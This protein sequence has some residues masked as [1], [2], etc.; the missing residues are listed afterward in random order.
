MAMDE[1]QVA[2]V[3]LEKVRKKIPVLFD[4]EDTFFSQIEKGEVEVISNRDM[5]IPL[6]IRPGGRFGHFDPAGGDLGRGEGPGYEKAIINTVHLRH[7]IEWHKKTEWATDDARKAVVQTVKKLLASGMTEFRRAVDALAVSSDGT[8]TLGVV[9]GYS[10]A[11]GKDTLTCASD[12]YGVR[13]MR[14]GQMLSLYDST[15]AVRKPFVGAATINGE[16]PI[17]IHDLQNKLVRMNGAATTPVVGDKLVVSGLSGTP[18]TSLFGVPYHISN[19][20]VGA[21]QGLDR[22]LF[23]EIRSNRVNANNTPLA[24]PYARVALN[25]VGDRLGSSFDVG[26]QAWMHPAQVQAYEELGQLVMVVNK[27]ARKQ[28]LDLYFGDGEGWTLA[29]APIRKHFSWDK[30]RIDFLAMST[31]GRAEM[32]PISF[33]EVDGRKIFE[34]RGASGGV[35]ASQIF[36]VTG[37][38][39]IY[40]T[41]PAASSYIDNLA[42]PTGY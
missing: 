10:T 18:P 32:H 26:V 16:A 14:Y 21:W 8:G 1:T 17:D 27:E 28:N 34:I 9:S 20:S 6:E 15:L 33:Y 40:N 30:R 7:A 41:N 23:P 4:K 25:K 29:G 12:G 11:G 13:L 24:L 2:A 3:E 42:V 19:A 22:G 38:F 35:A 39:N 31:F 5:R 36:Y 37:S